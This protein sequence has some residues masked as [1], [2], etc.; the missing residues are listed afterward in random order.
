MAARSSAGGLGTQGRAPS[1]RRRASSA[2]TAACNAPRKTK[3]HRHRGRAAMVQRQPPGAA[4]HQRNHDVGVH[5]DA[6]LGHV[7]SRLQ[8]GASLPRRKTEG[9][10]VNQAGSRRHRTALLPLHAP[11]CLA[12]WLVSY[13]SQHGCVPHANQ[14]ATPHAAC[15]PSCNHAA[16]HACLHG[17]DLGVHGAQAAATQ[18]HHGVGLMQALQPAEIGHASRSAAAA[19]CSGAAKGR[20]LGC[21]CWLGGQL[22]WCEPCKKGGPAS[23]R[24]CWRFHPVPALVSQVPSC[25]RPSIRA[26]AAPH[27]A[28]LRVTSSTG[29]P[30]SLASCWHRRSR[31]GPSCSTHT[32]HGPSG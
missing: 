8:D 27:P 21:W 6:L 26:R 28:H 25:C 17:G 20:A 29:A 31:A 12:S 15:E 18:A 4:P 30:S 10:D 9:R 32:N 22:I 11:S 13:G 2:G 7:H 16:C 19:P 23:M 14:H 3:Q 24:L 5:A 1:C